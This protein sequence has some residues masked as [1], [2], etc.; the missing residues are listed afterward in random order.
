MGYS[1]SWIAVKA[2]PPQAI[3]DEFSFKMTDQREEI[4]ESDLTAVEM[5]GGWCLIVS[6]HTEQVV[7]DAAM[8]R[9]ASS[10]CEF[11]TCFVGEHAIVTTKMFP[12]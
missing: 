10:G 6:N 9:L 8:R 1:L 2:K 4:P 5:P 3:R 12:V 11:V 7:S